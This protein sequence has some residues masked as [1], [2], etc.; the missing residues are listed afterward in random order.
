MK[1]KIKRLIKR[2]CIG[3]EAS[4]RS[5]EMTGRGPAYG[6]RGNQRIIKTMAATALIATVAATAQAGSLFAPGG[7]EAAPG[8][9]WGPIWNWFRTNFGMEQFV[10][11]AGS[12]GQST[13]QA[14][15]N[16]AGSAFSTAP[17]PAPNGPGGGSGGNPL[18]ETA[19]R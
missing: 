2:I 14:Y 4:R 6:S 8:G 7:G 11:S 1:N 16:V 17:V 10:Q 9:F 19:K 5:T 15:S 3:L 13:P 18:V 12:I